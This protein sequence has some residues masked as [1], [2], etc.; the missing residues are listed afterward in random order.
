MQ[1][2]SKYGPELQQVTDE[3][4]C[5]LQSPQHDRHAASGLWVA[6][7]RPLFGAVRAAQGLLGLSSLAAQAEG[8]KP[9]LRTPKAPCNCQFGM[10]LGVF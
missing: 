1:H 6:A 7:Q 9:K 5:V 3:K 8:S 10:Y 2:Q 4:G